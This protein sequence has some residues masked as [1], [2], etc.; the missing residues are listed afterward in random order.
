MATVYLAWDTTHN[1]RVALK[2]LQPDL[3]ASLGAERFRREIA[4]LT[5]LQHPHI[6]GVHES[7]E[8]AGRLWF[9]TP[10]IAGGSLRDRLARESPLPIHEAL[11]ITREMAGALDYAHGRGII[12]RDLKP[13]NVLLTDRGRTLLADFGIAR[14]LGATSTDGVTLTE[15]GV[16]VGTPKYMSPEQ[17]MGI[18]ALDARS[19]VYTLGTV[20]YEMLTG[21]LPFPGSSGLAAALRAERLDAPS[22]RVA[23]P[24]VAD[25]V[26]AALRSALALAPADRWPSAGE[27]AHALDGAKRSVLRTRSR[28]SSIRQSA[29]I[30]LVFG[31]VVASAGVF[32]WL[33]GRAAPV[34]AAPDAVR[35]A[36]LPF[37]NVGDSTDAYFADGV[38]D[39][40]RGKLTSIPGLQVIG[41]T[42]SAQYR[43]TTK[44]PRD[45]GRE[46]GVRYL[47]EGKVRWAKA[48]DGTSRVRVISELVDVR[49]AADKWARPFD[50]PLTDVFQ[51][52]SSIAGQ[53]ARELEIAL[54]PNAEQMLVS[55]PTTN[56]TAYDAYLRGQALANAV[57]PAAVRGAVARFEEAVGRD[58]TFALAWAA[59]AQMQASEYFDA[60]TY[61]ADA[62]R[63][64]LADSADRNSSRALALAPD[65]AAAHA[66]RATY[67]VKVRPDL[68][69][70]LREDSLALALAPGDANTLA[71]TGTVER[72]VGRW[73]AAELHT[74]EAAR[75]EPRSTIASYRIGDLEFARGH[76]NQARVAFEHAA[77]LS[78][79]DLAVIDGRLVLALAQGDL[80]GGRAFLRSVSPT[81]DRDNLVAYL[82]AYGD[83]GWALDSSDA[84]R[85][86][87]LGPEA[88]DDDRAAWALAR[89][90]QYAFGGDRRRTRIYADTARLA[91]ETQI[92]A[93]PD[94][95]QRHVL[96]GVAL[97]YLGRHDAA[98]REG[99]RAVALLPIGRD[100]LVGPY[101]QHQLIRIY[102]LVGEPQRAL[103]LLDRLLRIP[104]ALS[105]ALLRIDPNFAPLRGNPRFERLLVEISPVR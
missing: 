69:R 83:L 36:V 62:P 34:A 82:A 19:D 6:L 61:S 90:Q 84:E 102:M 23:R 11:R 56:V 95:A 52:Q 44:T 40:V 50:A 88:F 9:T 13:E 37:E 92:T 31:V 100:A 89:A 91:F 12:H 59:L 39:A 32:T 105:P 80:V 1:R 60:A 71:I 103:D 48:P 26:D 65:L 58:S 47:L 67:Y 70:A 30:V 55:Q 75:L 68:A 53:V 94:D 16:A 45:I 81:V 42:S 27:F 41:S 24:G 15:T 98:I 85:L 99:E 28:G 87:R 46:L 17:A 38:T 86:L 104:Y 10:Y 5:Q 21:E 2:V 20:C 29:A 8:T 63:P 66:A 18:R 73:D 76:Y 3:G 97:A 22:V 49:T 33:H 79:T 93:A 96:V 51:V 43:H 14:T 25:H 72:T 57:G 7:G 4:T 64:A 101:I 35:L 74:L 78:P 54:T 77:A